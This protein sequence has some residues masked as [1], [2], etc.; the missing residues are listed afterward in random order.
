QRCV[1]QRA[2]QP[3]GLHKTSATPDGSVLSNVDELY[4]VALG[5]EVP[6]TYA[7]NPAAA[8]GIEREPIDATKGWEVDTY[9]GST[10]YRAFGS[11]GGGRSAFVRIPQ[12]RV[13][14]IIL[15]NDESADARGMADQI[16]EKLLRGS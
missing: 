16:A 6:R 10:R 11:P 9:R 15:T 8:P 2:S 4:R 12:R 3:V 13:T 14:I 5:L 1:A 7:R